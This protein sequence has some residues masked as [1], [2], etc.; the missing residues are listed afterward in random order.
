MGQK[1]S[2]TDNGNSSNNKDNLEFGNISKSD[3]QTSSTSSI[4]ATAAN[5]ESDFYD[6]WG[7][8][9][10]FEGLGSDFQKGSSDNL[11][12]NFLPRT[13]SLPRPVTEPPIYVLESS[14]SFQHLWYETAGRR[15][16]QPIDERVHFEKLWQKNFEI[17][18][19]SYNDGIDSNESNKNQDDVLYR[20]VGPFT[21]S[22][23][24][25][26]SNVNFSSIRIQVGYQIISYF[27]SLI[28][29][30]LNSCLD[31]SV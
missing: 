15:P 14:L 8:F 30:F 20:G 9:Q 11:A 17:S 28:F 3:G 2:V 21:I 27:I 26:F 7:W 19:V 16:A 25:T 12:E 10:D 4:S 5:Y 13:H 6:P 24:K 29:F 18:T 22:V 23:S 31:S 1:S